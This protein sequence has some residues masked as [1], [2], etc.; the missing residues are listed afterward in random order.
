[1]L[2]AMEGGNVGNLGGV[3]ARPEPMHGLPFSLSLTLPPLATLILQPRER[4]GSG[5]GPQDG[6]SAGKPPNPSALPGTATGVN[7]ALFSENAEKVDLCLFSE[8]GNRELERIPP[9]RVHEPGMARLLRRRASLDCCTAIASTVPTIPI[10]GTDSIR[11]S[12]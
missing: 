9:A 11:T 1:M 12:C 8:S 3:T 2:T 6:A 4:V 7:F 5:S 10:G